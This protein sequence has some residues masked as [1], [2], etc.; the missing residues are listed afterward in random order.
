LGIE[1]E[2]IDVNDRNALTAH[3]ARVEAQH[4]RIDLLVNCAGA[5]VVRPISDLSDEE[6]DNIF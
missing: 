5:N 3:L 6:W 1:T 2:C 4:G